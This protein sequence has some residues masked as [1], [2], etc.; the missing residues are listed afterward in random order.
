MNALAAELPEESIMSRNTLL[1]LFGAA[2]IGLFGLCS[3]NASAF[4]QDAASG[5]V[6]G[7]W[8]EEWNI[9][10]SGRNIADLQKNGLADQLTHLFYA[11]GDVT[12]SSTPACAIADPSDA[13]LNSSIPSVSG[14]PYT[15]PL[16]GNYGAIL[17]LKQLHPKLGVLISLGGQ[18]GSNAG[19][20]AAASSAAGRTALAASCIDLFI[21]GNIAPGVQ[22]PGLFDGFN[23]DWEFPAAADKENFTALLKEFRAQLDV[24]AK[25]TGKRYI[26]SFDSPAGKQNYAN[27]DLKAAAE[28]VDFLTVDGYD[29]AG[30]ADQQS[31]EQSPLY[32]SV[33]NPLHGLG[34]SIDE[35]V[36]AY[37]K[38]GVPA[39][40]YTMGLPA[41]GVGWAGVANVKHGLYQ[42]TAGAAPVLRG[43]GTGLCRNLSGTNNPAGCDSL[44]TP[45]F[46]TYATIQNLVDKNGFVYWYD[47]ARVEATVYN[48]FTGSFYS[49]DDPK[50]V[51]AKTAYIKKHKL[52]GVYVWALNHDDAEGALTKAVLNG[53]K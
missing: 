45:G 47:S 28:Q 50:S 48:P 30:A 42:G 21:K 37:L 24:L 49:Y 15:A 11:F 1:R 14:K 38:A 43:D 36:K 40:K 12:A 22:A 35:T 34:F 25:T 19:W 7:A 10:Y 46:V 16:Y 32:D 5:S 20:V 2:S 39:A 26:L 31:N 18:A 13:Y 41:Y 44:L 4:A 27:I 53:L 33:E 17:Q 23:I 29:Y 3:W 9:H 51:A 6:H 8:F 52:G